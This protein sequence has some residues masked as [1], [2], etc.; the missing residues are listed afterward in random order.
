MQCNPYIQSSLYS[1]YIQ[2]V[3]ENSTHALSAVGH[4]GL[5]SQYIRD[6]VNVTRFTKKTYK[7]IQF[8][9]FEDI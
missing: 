3:A 8:F 4:G 6:A 7:H 9:I 5:C 2:S 1:S